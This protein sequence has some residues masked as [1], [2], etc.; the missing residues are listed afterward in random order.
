MNWRAALLRWK[1]GEPMTEEKD[2]P[3]LNFVIRQYRDLEQQRSALCR[4]LMGSAEAVGFLLMRKAGTEQAG[5]AVLDIALART[6]TRE[7][8]GHELSAE[9]ENPATWPG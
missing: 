8:W 3:S 9:K 6:L 2:R 5:S 4:L 7:E 1:K